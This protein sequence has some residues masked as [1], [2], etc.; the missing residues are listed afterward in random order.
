MKD[1]PGLKKLFEETVDNYLTTEMK[2]RGRSNFIVDIDLISYQGSILKDHGYKKH[3]YYYDS[4]TNHDSP[5]DKFKDFFL[6]PINSKDRSVDTF[7]IPEDE[8]LAENET[9]KWT[10]ITYGNVHD[11]WKT[12]SLLN[13][14]NLN[15]LEKIKM[16]VVINNINFQ[17]IRGSM[18]PVIITVDQAENMYKAIEVDS[19]LKDLMN[20]N[21]NLQDEVIDTQ[22]TGYYYISGAKYC[23]DKYR[24]IGLYT[25]LFLAR[26]EWNRSKIIK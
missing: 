1:L 18:I 15:E 13:Q 14:H 2:D 23:Y 4:Q 26:R 3:L 16:K 25:E 11:N 12:A 9:K 20:Q 22:L 8:D 7:L 21:K 5:S 24:K 17:A 6:K 10:G 19:N